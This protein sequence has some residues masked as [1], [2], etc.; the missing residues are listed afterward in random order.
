[1][2]RAYRRPESAPTT[3]TASA[4]NAGLDSENSLALASMGVAAPESEAGVLAAAAQEVGVSTAGGS[5]EAPAFTA[6]SRTRDGKEQRGA[7]IKLSFMP[8]SSTD[9]DTI[10]LMQTSAVWKTDTS[11][12]TTAAFGNSVARPGRAVGDGSDKADATNIDRGDG[13]SSPF[14]G[15]PDANVVAKQN[16]LSSDWG[17][18]SIPVRVRSGAGKSPSAGTG[19][20]EAW[21]RD[22]V[23]QN[24]EDGTSMEADFEVAAIATSGTDKGLVYGTV[25]WG[26]TVDSGGGVSLEGPTVVSQGNASSTFHAAMDAWNAQEDY[27]AT[28]IRASRVKADKT[29][30]YSEPG[31]VRTSNDDWALPA[32]VEGVAPVDALP[33]EKSE[34]EKRKKAITDG[35]AALEKDDDKAKEGVTWR[36]LAFELKQVEAALANAE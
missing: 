1:M 14:F 30:E 2:N 18:T 13:Y 32:L 15:V 29:V 3:T 25:S 4:G 35:Q 11:K 17:V 36:Q 27:D 7:D 28:N 5:W 19:A 9:A 6:I 20:S 16:E 33:T 22:V 21:L 10:D 34:L 31:T 24:W 12:A 23:N 8:N 26:F